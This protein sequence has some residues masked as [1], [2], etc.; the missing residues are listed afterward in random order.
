MDFY[1]GNEQSFDDAAD[2]AYSAYLSEVFTGA[3]GEKDLEISDQI[4]SGNVEKITDAHNSGN[5]TADVYEEIVGCYRSF[6]RQLLEGAEIIINN[7]SKWKE[8]KIQRY[9][10]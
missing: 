9:K 8:P 4:L 3:Y 7:Q 1:I 10:L 6:S 2:I 5:F